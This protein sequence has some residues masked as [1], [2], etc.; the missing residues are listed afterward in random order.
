ML[1]NRN[2]KRFGDVVAFEL[3]NGIENFPTSQGS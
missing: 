3:N 1:L 2:D